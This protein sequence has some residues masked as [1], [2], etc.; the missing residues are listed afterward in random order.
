MKNITLA[1][2]EQ[3]LAAG[4]DYARRHNQSL[5]SLVRAL[6]KQRV[7]KSSSQWIQ[8]SFQLMDRA[9]ATSSGKRWRREELYRV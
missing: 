7:L 5:N 6:L 2:D 4:R 3:T 8:E 1:I 9:K